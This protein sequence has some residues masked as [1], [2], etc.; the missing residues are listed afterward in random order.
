MF[1]YFWSR[2]R[3]TALSRGG[4]ERIQSSSRLWAASTEPDTELEH[5]RWDH[6]LSRSR[7]LNPLSHPGAPEALL[8]V[9][10]MPHSQGW[11]LTVPHRGYW[12]AQSTCSGLWTHFVSLVLLSYS[13]SNGLYSGTTVTSWPFQPQNFSFLTHPL[14]EW[15]VFS[16]LLTLRTS[17]S[18]I[19]SYFSSCPLHWVHSFKFRKHT[20]VFILVLS[21]ESLPFL[22]K[23][24]LTCTPHF[25]KPLSHFSSLN[26]P[27]FSLGRNQQKASP[28][29]VRIQTRHSTTC[30]L[31]PIH[32]KVSSVS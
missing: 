23:V 31:V 6:H 2:K 14:W 17:L 21:Q 4:A 7:T 10:K 32:A 15:L 29:F 13:F 24:F 8:I 1:I 27:L 12:G 22:W 28:C 11:P 30:N 16:S 25:P 3:K 5:E 18:L 20:H 19:L 26:Q 9:L